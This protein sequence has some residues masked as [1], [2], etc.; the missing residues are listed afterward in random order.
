MSSKFEITFTP[1]S[2]SDSTKASVI[3]Y[4]ELVDRNIWKWSD[5]HIN[6]SKVGDFL[7]F[8]FH[9]RKLVF[10]KI[11]D[12]KGP[13]YRL[14]SWDITTRNVLI[15]SPPLYEI[16]WN[17][18]VLLK[19]P[20]SKNGT[21]TT[22]NLQKKWP[23]VYRHLLKTPTARV[24]SDYISEL[25]S[26]DNEYGDLNRSWLNEQDDPRVPHHTL[27]WIIYCWDAINL[28][29]AWNRRDQLLL[30]RCTHNNNSDKYS[31]RIL[32]DFRKIAIEYD[33]WDDYLNEKFEKDLDTGKIKRY[34]NGN[35]RKENS[36]ILDSKLIKWEYY[37][38]TKH[39]A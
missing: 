27:W 23:L 32:G 13:E 6:K 11:I 3:H 33:V 34:I 22:A 14:S 21:Y 39:P 25:V 19:G 7:A 28:P 1:I 16:T 36:V 2:V 8:Y 15:L 12:I 5:S 18:W 31:S 24:M 38:R 20:M 30:N 26:H 4:N 10:H 17:E 9:N 29:N 35:Q 37:E